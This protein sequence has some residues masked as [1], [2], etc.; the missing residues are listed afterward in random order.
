[1]NG[2]VFRN[3]D[4]FADYY[5][6]ALQIE[7]RL[8]GAGVDCFL[9]ALAHLQILALAFAVTGVSASHKSGSAALAVSPI[10]G[11]RPTKQAENHEQ[12]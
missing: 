9:S 8:V 3:N 7:D 12:G 6:C 5:A 1:M 10:P 4:W 11:K 2:F